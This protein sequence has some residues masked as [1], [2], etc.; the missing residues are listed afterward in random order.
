MGSKK[1]FLYDVLKA[2]CVIKKTSVEEIVKLAKPPFG[3]IQ[4]LK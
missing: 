4:K 1:F 3:T 2:W